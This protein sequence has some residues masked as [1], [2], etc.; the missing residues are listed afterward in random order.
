[1]S[2]RATFARLPTELRHCI[3]NLVLGSDGDAPTMVPFRTTRPYMLEEDDDDEEMILSAE[4]AGEIISDEQFEE[5]RQLALHHITGQNGTAGPVNPAPTTLPSNG[6]AREVNV[7]TGGTGDQ[8]KAN[9][10][11]GVTAEQANE[12]GNEDAAAGTTNEAPIEIADEND[13]EE[14]DEEEEEEEEDEDPEFEPGNPY[15]QERAWDDEVVIPVYG[16]PPLLLVNREARSIALDW[17]Q[18][19]DIQLAVTTIAK[20]EIDTGFTVRKG[21]PPPYVR[22]FNPKRDHLY[23]DRHYWRR[24]CDRLQMPHMMAPDDEDEEE[25]PVH[26]IGENI[27]NLALPAFTMYQSVGMVGHILE[28]LP[29]IQ[30]ISCIWGDL[31]EKEWQPSI[32][33]EKVK[34]DGKSKT[35]VTNIL[36]PRWDQEQISEQ[37]SEEE[38]DRRT[39]D[40]EKIKAE[41]QQERQAKQERKQKAEQEGK[42][43]EQEDEDDSDEDDDDEDDEEEEEGSGP[44]VTMCVRDPTDDKKVFYERGYLGDWLDEIYNELAIC[45]LPDHVTDEDDGSVTLPIVPCNIVKRQ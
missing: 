1:M 27:R 16:I 30:Q 7:G 13:D 26:D 39:A 14:D 33:Y 43:D 11:N 20:G 10:T 3:W 5:I 25:E 40:T 21:A 9:A 24:F 6:V 18:K 23:V 4:D 34:R 38:L 28:Y 12:Q 2:G 29:N 19:H 35:Q 41:R 8:R 45:E 37:L 32:V 22:K 44:I 36:I 15:T 42:K 17:L 31:P